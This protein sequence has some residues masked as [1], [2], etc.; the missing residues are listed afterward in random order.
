MSEQMLWPHTHTPMQWTLLF[1][2]LL[3]CHFL[4][5]SVSTRI[6]PPSSESSSFK[7]CSPLERSSLQWLMID[8]LYVPVS[9][10][11]L[12]LHQVFMRW[13]ISHLSLF[14]FP[15]SCPPF[16]H[17][18]GITVVTVA[19]CSWLLSNNCSPSLQPIIQMYTAAQRPLRL[20]RFPHFPLQCPKALKY[21]Y[22][23]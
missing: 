1:K 23:C 3:F 2:S 9:L 10:P 11:S 6:F 4:P 18:G 16:L 21:I 20:T 13:M 14:P 19:G 7:S 17:T 15:L 8:R 22:T 12:A 5:S